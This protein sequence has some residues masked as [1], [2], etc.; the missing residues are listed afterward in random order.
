[1]LIFQSLVGKVL[2][3]VN[4]FGVISDLYSEKTIR[5]YYENFESDLPPHIYLIGKMDVNNNL[6][7]INNFSIYNS[8]RGYE[9]DA[10]VQE[11][12]VNCLDGR[13]RKRQN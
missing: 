12:A 6:I 8:K 7:K 5:K 2:V 9:R 11:V 4:P 10:Y 3:A 1:M 13:D